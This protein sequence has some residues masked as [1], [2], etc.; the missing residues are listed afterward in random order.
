MILRDS[1]TVSAESFTTMTGDALRMEVFTDIEQVTVP[2][3]SDIG[4]GNLLSDVRIEATLRPVGLP[5]T[6]IISNLSVNIE[7]LPLTP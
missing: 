2:A 4:V 3:H 5:P 6:R 1:A 7:R